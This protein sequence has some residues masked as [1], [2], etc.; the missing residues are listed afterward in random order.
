MTI[1]IFEA[2]KRTVARRHQ[3]DHAFIGVRGD[4]WCLVE[5]LP[6]AEVFFHIIGEFLQ[7]GLNANGK[8]QLHHMIN[9]D[10]WNNIEVRL[11]HHYS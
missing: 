9:T 7:K 3:L 6:A 11:R 5:A 4:T 10:E 2:V 1:H 8:N